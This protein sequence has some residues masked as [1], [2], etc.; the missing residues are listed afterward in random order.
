[1]SASGAAG[2]A[3]QRVRQ[4]LADFDAVS[5]VAD[6]S[7]SLQE[8]FVVPHQAL[9]RA[10]Y[11]IGYVP[12]EDGEYEVFLRGDKLVAR[13]AGTEGDDDDATD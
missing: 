7:R 6:R 11:C 9:V 12:D 2:L 3:A 5:A 13:A 10:A 4:A 1:M 8:W